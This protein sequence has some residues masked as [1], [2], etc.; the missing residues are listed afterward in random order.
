VQRQFFGTHDHTLDAKGR[1][2]LPTD[3]RRILES[4]GSSSNVY[5]VPQLDRSDAHVVFANGAYSKLLDRHDA[6]N[7]ATPEAQEVMR[8]KLVARA[9]PVPVDDHG[10]I[11]L[12]QTLRTMIGLEKKV[13]F[14]G[15][16]TSFE[17]WKP[18]T[19]I[20]YEDALVANAGAEQVRIDRRG[21]Q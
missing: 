17:I 11:V 6:T 20:A 2:S 3:F 9:V 15:D 12:T 8:L 19:R 5:V 10:R 18:E 14:V 16:L 21:L 4:V 13:R 1:V 7:Y